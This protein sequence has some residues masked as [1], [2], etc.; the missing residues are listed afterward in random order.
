[1]ANY[2]TNTNIVKQVQTAINALGYQPALTVDGVYGPLTAKGVQWFEQKHGLTVDAGIIGDQVVA[3]TVAP[4]PGAA[5]SPAN[6][7]AKPIITLHLGPPP[8]ATALQSAAGAF[9]SPAPSSAVVAQAPTAQMLVT[10]V[11]V[12]A[13]SSI[14]VW[15]VTAVGLA[16]GAPAGWYFLHKWWL[17]AL[18]G[19]GAGAL[20]DLIRSAMAPAAVAPTVAGEFGMEVDFDDTLGTVV[21]GD[22]GVPSPHRAM[23]A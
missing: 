5:P 18:I 20:I 13:G 11:P 22:I 16:L 17:G 6:L 15:T 7:V 14:P 19:G 2:D 4:T 21:A 23:K 9:S 10:P 12:A 3:A 8:S 1:M